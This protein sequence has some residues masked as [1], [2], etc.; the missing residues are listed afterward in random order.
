V[1]PRRSERPPV[2]VP[3]I[4]EG[5]DLHIVPVRTGPAA[6]AVEFRIFSRGNPTNV[7]GCFSSQ[8]A[9]ALCAAILEAAR[10]A[11]QFQIFAPGSES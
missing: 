9:Q 8:H 7:G 1:S 11:S 6:P 2:G 5:L 3:L 4:V 10:E